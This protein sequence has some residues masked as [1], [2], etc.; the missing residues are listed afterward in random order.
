MELS[1]KSLHGVELVMD[2]ALK[3]MTMALDATL[4]GVLLK[5]H[6]ESA[7]EAY[8]R[9]QAQVAKPRAAAAAPV[10]VKAAFDVTNPAAVAWAKAHAAELIDGIE[11]TTRA[12]IKRLVEDAFDEEVEVY[13]LADQIAEVI[14]DSA[15][16]E[17]IA[18]TETMTASNVGQQNAWDQAVDDGLLTGDELQ[19]WIVTPDDRLCPVCDGLDGEQAELGGMFE[20]DGEQ[21]DG[22]PAH[23]NCRCTVGLALPS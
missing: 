8:R 9:V 2:S 14:G 7:A 6:N 23:P 19:E 22:P 18:R 20:A 17:E 5:T 1:N 12:D 3:A 15:R 16:A 11:E 21:Y 10:R 13:D 4:P